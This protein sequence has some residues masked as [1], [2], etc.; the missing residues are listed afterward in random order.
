MV[1]AGHA[2]GGAVPKES[3]LENEGIAHGTI[4]VGIRVC[5]KYSFFVKPTVLSFTSWL[6]AV[7]IKWH[8]EVVQRCVREYIML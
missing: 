4:Y 1:R 3:R 2:N 8:C 7:P 5:T 6:L